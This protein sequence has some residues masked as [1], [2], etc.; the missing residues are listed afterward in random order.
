MTQYTPP[1]GPNPGN[2][3]FQQPPPSYPQSPEHYVGTVPAYASSK[4]IAAGVLGILLGGLGIHKFILG[5]TGAGLTML[6]VSICTLRALYPVMYVIG[7]IEG[8]LYVTK[9]DADFYQTY[10]VN[11]K[12]WF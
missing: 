12:P 5:Y 6:L 11:K 10:I 8:I 4:K 1:S 3:G 7:V 9:S 2:P